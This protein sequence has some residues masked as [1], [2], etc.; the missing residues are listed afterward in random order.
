MRIFS[1]IFAHTVTAP[2]EVRHGEDLG[3]V[4]VGFR[5]LRVE[6][7][8]VRL[9]EHVRQDLQKTSGVTTDSN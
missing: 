9:H 6:R 4:L 7:V 8:D 2:D 1:H 5:F 3:V